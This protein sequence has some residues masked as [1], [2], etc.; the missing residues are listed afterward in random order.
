M[1]KKKTLWR[2]W[3]KSL[4]EKTGKND[5]EAD[6]IAIIRTVIFITYLIT[7]LFIIAGVVKHYND[8]PSTIPQTEKERIL[9][10]NSN[11][12]KD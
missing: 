2:L 9:N 7:N 11:I 4:G 10:T 1:K 3:A 5:R 6:Y 8:V 12:L